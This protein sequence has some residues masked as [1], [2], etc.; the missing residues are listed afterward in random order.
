MN[1]VT[2]PDDLALA[3]DMADRADEVTLWHFRQPDL[4]VESKADFTPV[5]EADRATEELLRQILADQRPDDAIVGEEYGGNEGSGRRWIIDPIDGTKNY[6]RGVP[7]WATLIALADGDS[8]VVGVVSAPALGRRWWAASGNGSWTQGPEDAS[9]R[10]NS[11]SEVDALA[12][13]SF[14]FS[15]GVDWPQGGLARV[16]DATWRSRAYGD[17]WSHM[18]VAEGVADVAAE[19]VLNIWDVAALVP[20]IE[21]AGGQ[22]TAFDG[23]PLISGT[24]AVTTNGVLH[25]EA[26]RAIHG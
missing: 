1:P 5:T 19:P 21:E 25:A 2:T 22:I 20:V 9:P 8:I 4:A 6:L 10:R 23:S 15:D 13:A 26:L 12:D 16:M 11:V 14:T 18:M 7:V 17:F 3:L 24:G